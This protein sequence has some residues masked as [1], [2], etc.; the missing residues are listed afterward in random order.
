MQE[1]TRI[2][3]GIAV[4]RQ[5]GLFVQHDRYVRAILHAL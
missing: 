1:K 4:S 2:V 3:A 5:I